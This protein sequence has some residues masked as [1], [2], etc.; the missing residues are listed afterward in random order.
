MEVWKNV[1]FARANSLKQFAM[2]IKVLSYA[3]KFSI[4]R[5]YRV[6]R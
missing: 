5:F 2:W 4:N 1:E 3:K 6:A